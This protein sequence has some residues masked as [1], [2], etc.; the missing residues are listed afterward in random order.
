MPWA[1]SSRGRRC[2]VFHLM[3]RRRERRAETP[4]ARGEPT[5]FDLLRRE[6]ASLFDRAFG[7]WPVPFEMSWEMTEH[8]GV[9][10]EE[11]D[12]EV[13][14]RAEVPGFE[15]SE[16]AVTLHDNLLTLRAEHREPAGEGKG[17]RR[18][19]RWEQTVMLPE[20]IDPDRVEATCRNGVLEVRVPRKPEDQPRRVEVKS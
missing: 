12:K 6:F 3:P 16:L 1:L 7:G 15:A 10:M 20:G 4:L 8:H 18:S 19:A 2:V 9:T 14:V 5:P 17:E 13:V 11:G